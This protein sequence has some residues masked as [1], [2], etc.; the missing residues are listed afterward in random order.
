MF[1]GEFDGNSLIADPMFVDPKNRVYRLKEESP[2]LQLG[3][4][5]IDV[6]DIG[7]KGDF[8]ARL[9]ESPDEIYRIPPRL[10]YQGSN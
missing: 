1:D 10:I 8:P 6:S 7:F 4:K 9:R 5:D 3:F 2:A